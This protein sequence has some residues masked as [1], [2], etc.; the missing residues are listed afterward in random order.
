MTFVRSRGRKMKRQAANEVEAIGIGRKAAREAD[1]A[2]F[3][4]FR[5]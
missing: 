1:K 3:Q 5:G 2:Q 4:A